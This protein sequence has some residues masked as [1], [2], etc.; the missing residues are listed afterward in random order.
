MI[1]PC[2]TYTNP[3]RCFG[4]AAVWANAEAAGTM[5]SSSGKATV[6]PR[7]RSTVRRG[8]AFFVVIMTLT[9]WLSVYRNA[10]AALPCLPERLGGIPFLKRH[11]LHDTQYER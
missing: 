1:E 7:P 6:A 9:S 5:P 4:A 8:M 3:N 11:A 2:G 10:S